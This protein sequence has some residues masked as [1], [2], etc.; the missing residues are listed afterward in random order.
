VLPKAAL[1]AGFSFRFP[2]LAGALAD[3]YGEAR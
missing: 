3:L 2:T 1:A